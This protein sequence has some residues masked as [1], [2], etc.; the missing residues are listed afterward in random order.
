MEQA[1]DEAWAAAWIE[2]AGETEGL[3]A[4]PAITRLLLKTLEKLGGSDW[5]I[6]F[7][8]APYDRGSFTFYLADLCRQR[9]IRFCLRVDTHEA[10]EPLRE[11]WACAPLD[12]GVV[13]LRT[14]TTT[15]PPP[16]YTITIERGSIV[17]T[18]RLHPVS[19]GG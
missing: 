3:S 16:L 18:E 15:N 13:L 7:R 10:L 6:T 4:D 19:E 11:S 12:D 17:V 9:M 8:A 14:C 2:V 1:T 5:G